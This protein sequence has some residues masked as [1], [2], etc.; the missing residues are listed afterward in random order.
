MLGFRQNKN[1]VSGATTALTKIALLCSIPSDRSV[2][3]ELTYS[4]AF[5]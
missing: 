1:N 5:G 4:T 3:M 2:A